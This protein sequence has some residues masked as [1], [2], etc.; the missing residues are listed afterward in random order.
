MLSKCHI[1]SL[2]TITL[3][4]Y[5]SVTLQCRNDILDITYSDL[6]ATFTGLD[7]TVHKEGELIVHHFMALG[8]QDVW[9][10]VGKKGEEHA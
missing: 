3:H 2:F 4:A 7:I 5:G 8:D 10:Y 1:G 6:H 9:A